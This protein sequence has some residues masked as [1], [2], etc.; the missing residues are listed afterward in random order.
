MLPYLFVTSFN[1]AGY[2]LY[3]KRMLESFLTNWDEQFKIMVYFEDLSLDK[4][5]R[6]HPRIILRDINHVPDL[7]LFKNRHAKNLKA[8]GYYHN[9]HHKEFQYDA[10]RFSH[11]VFALYD[12]FISKVV[13]CKS[14]VW[15]DADT[16]TFGKV[17]PEFIEKVAP[18]NFWGSS[19]D[20]K[21]KYG[22]CYLGR[23]AQH[24]ECGFVAYN[25]THPMMHEFWDAFAN[26]YKTDSLFALPEWHDSFLFDHVR[27]LFEIKGMVNLNLTPHMSKGHPFINC[28]L[29]MYMDHM[30]GSR[31][32]NGRSRKTERLIK[33]PD[34]PDWWK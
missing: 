16:Y 3:G 9:E 33:G 11:K 17:P 31:K 4:S 28:D 14:M 5:L 12:C 18:R 25:C 1:K 7:I 27:K 8:H 21:Q 29:G 20:G 2:N 34:Q 26:L 13:P 24:S 6:E 19:G 32:K 10:V 30:K 23:T 22:I 15:I